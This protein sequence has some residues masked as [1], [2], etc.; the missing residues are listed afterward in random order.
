MTEEGREGW[1]DFCENMIGG[2]EY[3]TREIGD[4]KYHEIRAI[5]EAAWKK[6]CETDDFADAI[7]AAVKKGA[8]YNAT[9]KTSTRI[10][11]DA[12]RVYVN[13]LEG[14]RRK[15]LDPQLEGYRRNML[16]PNACSFAYSYADEKT[17]ET[18]R[19]ELR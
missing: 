3:R 4:L 6:L 12:R 7:I 14:Y 11:D 10:A 19:G 1:K 16:Y 18:K 13:Q 9:R 17:S 15:Y 8:G 2:E 5:Y